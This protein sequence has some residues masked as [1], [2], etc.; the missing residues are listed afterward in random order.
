MSEKDS[1]QNEVK[2]L[3]EESNL[4]ARLLEDANL[5]FEEKVGE[6]SLLRKIGDVISSTFDLESFCREMVTII[7][8]ETSVSFR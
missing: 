4:Y 2:R 3:T 5:R 1:I 7:I 6:L 8:E